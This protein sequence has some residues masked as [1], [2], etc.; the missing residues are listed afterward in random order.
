V[1]AVVLALSGVIVKPNTGKSLTLL[2]K[3]PAAG[4]LLVTVA[5]FLTKS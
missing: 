2:D 4:K 1:K 3:L 5:P